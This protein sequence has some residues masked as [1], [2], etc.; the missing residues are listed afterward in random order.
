MGHEQ[1]LD[2]TFMRGGLRVSGW[3]TA[4]EHDGAWPRKNVVDVHSAT[5]HEGA[6]AWQKKM[7]PKRGS[8]EIAKHTRANRATS[9]VSATGRDIATPQ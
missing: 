3:S 2:K 7:R 4:M 6:K 9:G 8:A 5:L 1:F